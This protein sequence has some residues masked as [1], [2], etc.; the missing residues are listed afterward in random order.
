MLAPDGSVKWTFPTGGEIVSSAAV[1]SDGTVYFGSHDGKFYALDPAGKKR[2]QTATG[3]PIIS[4]PAIGSD[5]ALYFTS[6]DGYLYAVN[7]DGTP[8]WKLHTGGI[9]E[10]SPVLATDGTLY[11]GVNTNLWSVTA[12]GKQNWTRQA[13]YYIRSAPLALSDGTVC[14]L[15]DFGTLFAL[16]NEHRL[17]WRFFLYGGAEAAPVVAPSGIIYAAYGMT[18]FCA[19]HTK[20]PLARSSWPKFR[21]NPRNTGNVRD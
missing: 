14:L 6:V 2:W 5:G 9:T 11:L 4:S 8:R 15:S 16:D 17:M 1:G 19:V 18:S 12:E 13:E 21:G 20:V 7:G 10:S 3:G